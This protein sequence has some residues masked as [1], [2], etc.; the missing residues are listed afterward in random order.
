MKRFN[1]W[2]CATFRDERGTELKPTAGYALD[3]RRWLDD[4]GETLTAADRA[5]LVRRA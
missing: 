1:E 5:E 4:V 2:Y 3:A